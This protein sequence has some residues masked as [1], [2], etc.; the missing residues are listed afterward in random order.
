MSNDYDYVIYHKNCYD[1]FAGFIVL[2]YSNQIKKNALIYPDNPYSTT[3]PP[4]IKGKNVIIIDVAYNKKILSDIFKLAKKTIFI[5]HHD[6]IR[7]D[8]LN[9]TINKTT[10][11]I[12]KQPN[13]IIYDENKSGCS[14][15][16]EYLYKNQ[17]KPSFIKYIE[18]NDIGK[19]K[20][21]ETIPFINALKVSYDAQFSKNNILKWKK[22]YEDKEVNLLIEKGL[23]YTEYSNFIANSNMNKYS[24]KKF[25]SK[26]IY[27]KDKDIF[28]LLKVKVGGYIVAVYNG[29]P[30]PDVKTLSSVIFKNVKCDFIIFWSFD[31]NKNIYILQFR[32]LKID[33]GK[34]AK[35]F[36]GGGHRL[37]S[38]CSISADNFTMLDLFY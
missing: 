26:E 31:L 4:N 21:K 22:L 14:L 16:W 7:D 3:I 38:A 28:N 34:I 15:T 32:S 37:A 6:S 24:I 27:E 10:N 11:E 9:L 25:P 1:G 8:V 12:I 20:Y 36:N 19:W 35:I 23:L 30:C 13:E 29:L 18:D 17:K 5:D 33:V 2:Y